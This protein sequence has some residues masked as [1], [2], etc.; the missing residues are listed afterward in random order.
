MRKTFR[1]GL[2]TM[3]AVALAL[4][5]MAPAAEACCIPCNPWCNEFLQPE[6]YCCT[7]IPQPDNPCGLTICAKWKGYKGKEADVDVADLF[8]P[9]FTAADAAT[10]TSCQEL[11]P[12]LLPPA[13]ETEEAPASG[14]V[15]N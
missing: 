2:W 3:T 15:E 13:E 9:A 11:I 1:T 14:D 6:D 8:A 10:G 5:W 12:G 4:L 7:G